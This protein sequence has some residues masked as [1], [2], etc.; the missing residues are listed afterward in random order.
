MNLPVV[1]TIEPFY[2]ENAMKLHYKTLLFDLDGTLTDSAEGILNCVRYALDKFGIEETDPV[3]LNSFIGPPLYD[4]FKN[5]YP[6]LSE[7]QVREAVKIYRSRYKDTCAIENKLYDGIP[8]LIGSLKAAGYR[9][10]LATAKPETFALPIMKHFALYDK[11]DLLYGCDESKNRLNKDDVIRDIIADN[12][13]MNRDNTVMIGDRF[14]DVL[15]A[16]KSGLDC[17]GVLYGFGDRAELEG[18]GAKYITETVASLG[19]LFL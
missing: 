19:E 17:I 5:L 14:H 4:S 7:E 12:P 9:L 13:D 3:R 6:Q 18:A 10:C 16:A 11:F 15:G 2:K 1:F 8:E